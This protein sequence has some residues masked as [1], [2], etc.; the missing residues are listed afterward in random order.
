MAYIEYFYSAHSLFAYIGAIR[1][2]EIAGAARCTI[3]HRPMDLAKV[4]QG[5]G[6]TPFRERCKLH[7]AYF[8]DREEEPAMRRSCRNGP[9]ITTM[10]RRWPIVC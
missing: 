10:T 2:G 6:S 9:S 7:F 5:V 1:L 8:F 4:M 3:T